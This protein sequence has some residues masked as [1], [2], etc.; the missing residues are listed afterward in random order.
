[1]GRRQTKNNVLLALVIFVGTAAWA[2]PGAQTKAKGDQARQQPAP[3]ASSAKSGF[4]RPETITGTILMVE[5]GE[6]V[7]ILARYG[8]TEPPSTQLVGTTS[9]MTVQPGPGETNYSFRITSST[10]I[11]VGGRPATVADLGKLQ[12][13]QATV[14]FIP[15]RGGNF[16]TSLEISQ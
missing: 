3:R 4:G 2:R 1:M 13:K 6:G 11:K 16:A 15:K 12:N 5:P 14:H 10:V 7:V 8:P 9:H